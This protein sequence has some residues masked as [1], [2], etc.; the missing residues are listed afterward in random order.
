MGDML[1]MFG[2]L[3][4]LGRRFIHYGIPGWTACVSKGRKEAWNDQGKESS[5]RQGKR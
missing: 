1:G 3:E 4:M 5:S 2:V